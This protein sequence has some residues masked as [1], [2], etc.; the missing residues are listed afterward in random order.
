ME[1]NFYD[2]DGDG[3]EEFRSVGIGE[4]GGRCDFAGG[5]GK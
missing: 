4:R 5:G 2:R 1:G 3:E